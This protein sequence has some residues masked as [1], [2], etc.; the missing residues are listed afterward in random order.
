[1]AIKRDP[2]GFQRERHRQGEYP[3]PPQAGVQPNQLPKLQGWG[4]NTTEYWGSVF[5]DYLKRRRGI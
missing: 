5:K 4:M 2:Y 1:M 3:R